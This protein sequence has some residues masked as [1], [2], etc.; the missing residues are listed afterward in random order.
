MVGGK[1]KTLG[2]LGLAC[3]CGE[4][5][6]VTNKP[7][8]AT[9]TASPHPSETLKALRTSLIVSIKTM[10]STTASANNT[11]QAISNFREHKNDHGIQDDQPLEHVM[12]S[13]GEGAKFEA[14][15]RSIPIRSHSN[16]YKQTQKSLD[17]SGA[18][19]KASPQKPT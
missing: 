11:S 8:A 15:D 1:E 10:E 5:A 3:Y 16:G 9:V 19:G 6:L 2:E 14:R 13:S 4:V 12:E 7:R 17:P 18:A